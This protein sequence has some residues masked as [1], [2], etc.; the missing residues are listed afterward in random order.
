MASTNTSRTSHSPE[1]PS[2][3]LPSSSRSSM[4]ET[5][6]PHWALLA[7]DRV[8]GSSGMV[9]V[10][11]YHLPSETLYTWPLQTDPTAAQPKQGTVFVAPRDGSSGEHSCPKVTSE[12]LQVLTTVLLTWMRGGATRSKGK[13]KLG[14][15]AEDTEWLCETLKMARL[16]DAERRA[17]LD[18][19]VVRPVQEWSGGTNADKGKK[20]VQDRRLSALNTNT[21]YV[22]HPHGDSPTSTAS[23]DTVPSIEVSSPNSTDI[24]SKGSAPWLL[25][26]QPSFVR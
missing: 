10:A 3:P 6:G 23:G 11:L 16:G 21:M 4:A 24:L 26:K 12:S 25:H 8:H 13:L 9:L 5:R 7:I 17:I 20:R 14:E 22:T 19:Q 18:L 1:A 2:I 15:R